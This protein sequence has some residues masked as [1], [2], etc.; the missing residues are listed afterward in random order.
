[1]EFCKKCGAPVDDG[2]TLC[3]NCRAQEEAEVTS[4]PEQPDGAEPT[5]TEPTEVVETTETAETTE[6][7]ET[8]EAPV[9]PKKEISEKSRRLR[10]QIIMG[11]VLLIAAIAVCVV[12]YVTQGRPTVDAET[13]DTALSTTDTASDDS[14]DSSDTTDTDTVT[15]EYTSYTVDADSVTDE[16][17][18][19]VVATCA[20]QE[21]TNQM[22]AY[23]YWYSYSS[24][25]NTYYT[26][27]YYYGLLDTTTPLDEQ[28]CYFDDSM[29]WQEYFVN[30]AMNAFAQFTLLGQRAEEENFVLPDDAQN[31]L[32]T[33]KET[34]QSAADD[35]GFDSIDAY[36]QEYYGV[37]ADYDSYYEFMRQYYTALNYDDMIYNGFTFTDSE[38][39]DYYDEHADELGVDKDDTLMV[40]VRHILIQPET[41]D[42]ITDDDG[43]VDEEATE[44]AQ[45]EANAA[46]LAELQE[47]YDEWLAGDATEDSFGN[48]AYMNSD[49][50]GSYSNGGLYENVYPG[51]MLAEFNDWCFDPSRQPGDTGIVE[52]DYGYHLLYFVGYG[53][54][55]YWRSVTADAMLTAA[56]SDF[57]NELMEADDSVQNFDVVKLLDPP[58]LYGDDSETE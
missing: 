45:E 56:Y 15:T 5:T 54:T 29:S 30:N 24:F 31:E 50:G 25:L 10:T 35:G 39:S 21:L 28:S 36:L 14:T 9:T 37:F 41:V 42:D 51:E 52:T 18:L 33:L 19:A 13:E 47:L 3:S 58:G 23:Y 43:N 48:L 49:D 16:D 4:T 7:E 20:G 34:L 57:F 8:A 2:E 17:K 26:Y 44:A 1:M 53:D 11:A 12:V 27:V 40:N 32:D 55:S 6:A 38:V 46:A 22:L